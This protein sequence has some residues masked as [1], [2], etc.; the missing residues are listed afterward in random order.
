MDNSFHAYGGLEVDPRIIYYILTKK[1]KQA[2]FQHLVYKNVP[3]SHR[4]GD[5]QQIAKVLPSQ[6]VEES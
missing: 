5:G 3:K 1:P 2:T 4:A 6:N